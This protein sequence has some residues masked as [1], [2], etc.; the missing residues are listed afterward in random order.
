MKLIGVLTQRIRGESGVVSAEYVAV[1]A[2]GI[3]LAITATWLALSD[4]LTDAINAAGGGLLEFIEQ[5][6]DS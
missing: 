6:G 1:T 2:V 3:L 5:I 4:A